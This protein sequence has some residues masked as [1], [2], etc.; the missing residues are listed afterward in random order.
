[1]FGL[2]ADSGWTSP[3]LIAQP[4][5]TAPSPN[6]FGDYDHEFAPPPDDDDDMTILVSFIKIVFNFYS[7][8]HYNILSLVLL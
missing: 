4:Y 3:S 7:L 6:T 2:E 8:F 5:N 1:M